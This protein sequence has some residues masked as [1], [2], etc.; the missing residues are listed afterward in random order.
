MG[1]SGRDGGNDGGKALMSSTRNGTLHHGALHGG[2]TTV[3]PTRK[4]LNFPNPKLDYWK[5]SDKELISL[6]KRMVTLAR[7]KAADARACKDLQ[8]AEMLDD[9]ARFASEKINDIVDGKVLGSEVGAELRQAL[10]VVLNTV[11]MKN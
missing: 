2:K 4:S 5:A 3:A 9:A 8:Y 1:R 7:F 6:A 11:N 10:N